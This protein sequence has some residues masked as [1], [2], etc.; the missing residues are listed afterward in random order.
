MPL[1][2]VVWKWGCLFSPTYVNRMRSMLE[3]HLHLPHQ[4]HCI[5]EDPTGIDA[6]V[7]IVPMPKEGATTPRCRRRMWQFAKER[8][9]EFGDRMLCVD[10]DAVIVDDITPIVDRYEP[11]VCWRVGYANVFSGSFIMFDT[12][13]LDGAW[14]AYQ[15]DPLGFPMSGGEFNGS[16]QAMINVWLRGKKVAEW[17]ER[18]GL[19]T[20]FGKGYEKKVM[21]G[22]GPTNPQ[23]PKGAKI[24]VLGSADKHVMDKAQFPFVQD[25]WH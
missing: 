25:H 13:A 22:M 16:D 4:L 1:S 12:G 10:L 17:T 20:W 2:V 23:L 14:Q 19:V 3:R 5:T 11:I 7:R 8:F 9:V 18:D 21:L 15:R 6:R 24:V